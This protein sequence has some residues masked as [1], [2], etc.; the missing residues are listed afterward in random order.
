[1]TDAQHVF[2]GGFNGTLLASSDGGSTW[3]TA[4]QGEQGADAFYQ[5]SFSTPLNGVAL[6]SGEQ[7]LRTTDGGQ[8]WGPISALG[9]Q[10]REMEWVSPTVGFAGTNG[11]LLKTTDGGANFTL[12]SGDPTCPYIWGMDFKNATTGIV[13]GGKQGEDNGLFKT[14]DGGVTWTRKYTGDCNT[15]L[16]ISGSEWLSI[17]RKTVLRSLN[18]GESWFPIGICEDGI[19][20]MVK[21]GTSN[22]LAGVGVYGSVS[23]SDDGGVTWTKTLTPLGNVGVGEWDIHFADNFHGVASGQGGSIYL[24][25]DGGLTWNRQTSGFAAG[26]RDMRMFDSNLGLAVGDFGYIMRT[27]NGGRFWEVKKTTSVIPSLRGDL[28]TLSNVGR[29]H[30]FAAGQGGGAFRSDD[31]GASWQPIGYPKLPGDL[32]IYDIE[33]TSPSD[34]WVVGTNIS[35][36]HRHEAIYRTNDGGQ[37]WTLNDQGPI[38][39]TAFETKGQYAWLTDGYDVIWRSTDGF[40]THTVQTLPGISIGTMRDLKFRDE[41]EGWTVGTYGTAFHTGNGGQTWEKLNIGHL[42]DGFFRVTPTGPGKAMAI[43]MMA[44]PNTNQYGPVLYTFSNGG[45]TVQRQFLF[46]SFEGFYAIGA[47]ADGNIW[48]GGDQGRIDVR[49][50][51]EVN[52]G[53]YSLLIGNT[54]SGGLDELTESDDRRFV[55]GFSWVG[56]RFTPNLRIEASGHTLMPSTA[57]IDLM[58]EAHTSIVGMSQKI[59]MFNYS[60]NAWDV[61]DTSTTSGS[62]STRTISITASPT[63][64]RGPDGALKARVEYYAVGTTGRILHARVDRIHWVVYP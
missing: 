35:S 11:A 60:T 40:L 2:V 62:D 57:R 46:S 29:D 31:A 22:R 51:M 39:W 38:G 43:A 44:D 15:V 10:L 45:A 30:W 27:T 54:V 14:T 52:P 37:T 23:I 16:H 59:L 6:S 34:G 13:G 5:I 19:G 49:P 42:Y 24:T 47:T 21:V 18:D 56:N 41:S 64:Y 33:F 8:T 32:E 17:D 55:S 63:N 25:L 12:M 50:S 26:I 4:F 20:Q 53:A 1:M 3:R 9:A 28:F 36:L 58:V 48:L 61:V 7:N